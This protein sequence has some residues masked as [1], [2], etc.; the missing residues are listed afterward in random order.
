MP[1]T[2]VTRAPTL[3]VG[4]VG[5]TVFFGLRLAVPS[6]AVWAVVAEPSVTPDLWA[7]TFTEILCPSRLS[8]G[9]KVRSVAPLIG[10]LLSSQT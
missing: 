9:L 5:L 4:N 6:S 1:G 3:G 8:P 2:A 7:V 10:A